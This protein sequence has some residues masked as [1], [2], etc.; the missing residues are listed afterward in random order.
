MNALKLRLIQSILQCEDPTL[1]ELAARLFE[2]DHQPPRDGT[3]VAPSA[4]LN[5]PQ[6]VSAEEVKDIQDQLDAFF[7]KS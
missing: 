3:E 5:A 4:F 7:G 6:T 1:L 2:L